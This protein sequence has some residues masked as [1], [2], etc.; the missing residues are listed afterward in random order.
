VTVVLSS[1]DT[2][3]FFR[4]GLMLAG[5][6]GLVYVLCG[7]IGLLEWGSRRR[8]HDVVRLQG[9]PW[10]QIQLAASAIYFGIAV[11]LNLWEGF[12]GEGVGIEWLL[13]VPVVLVPILRMAIRYAFPIRLHKGGDDC[14]DRC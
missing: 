7:I 12:I 2:W 11:A 13:Y 14:A 10:W 3:F 9:P 8:R 5:G 4:I 1:P 6:C